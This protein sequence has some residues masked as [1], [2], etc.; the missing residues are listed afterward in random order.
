MTTDKILAAPALDGIVAAPASGNV[1]IGSA[2]QGMIILLTLRF[3]TCA[4]IHL[5]A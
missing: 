2:N 4:N 1:I 3:N 5:H